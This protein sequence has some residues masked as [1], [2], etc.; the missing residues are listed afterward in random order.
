MTFPQVVGI[1]SPVPQQG[2]STVAKYLKQKYGYQVV[3]FATPLKRM[4][5]QFLHAM[6]YSPFEID[7]FLSEGKSTRLAE[8]TVDTRHILQT[9][10]TEWGRDC[11][12]P[13]VWVLCWKRQVNSFLQMGIPVVCDDLRFINEYR[14][15]RHITPETAFWRITRSSFYDQIASHP[16]EGFAENNS[17]VF[18][19][20]EIHNFHGLDDL[21]KQIDQVLETPQHNAIPVRSD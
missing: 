16:S 3:S 1:Y 12:H 9:L 15:L 2:K 5:T 14:A 18:I 4:A 21:T 6:G 17:N 10:G 20:A 19:D 13:D 7:G 8:I 11:I